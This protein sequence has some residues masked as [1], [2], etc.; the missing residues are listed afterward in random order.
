[1]THLLHETKRK[2]LFLKNAALGL[3]ASDSTNLNPRYL[4]KTISQRQVNRTTQRKTH[5]D[6]QWSRRNLG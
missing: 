4:L 2:D 3:K 5:E 1:M 6:V